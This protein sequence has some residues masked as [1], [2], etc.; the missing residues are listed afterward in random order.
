[1]SQISLEEIKTAKTALKKK[2]V[3]SVGHVVSLLGCST[4][5]VRLK[6]K[7]WNAYTSYNQNGRY[8]TLPGVPRFDENGL[9]RYQDVYFSRYGTL[10][11][12]VVHLIGA[13][14]GGLTGDQLGT[15][16]G[17]SPRSF[18]HHFRDISGIRREKH[19]GVYVYFSDDWDRYKQ[20][21]TNRLEAFSLP[22]E[23]I[24]DA[25]AVSILVTLIQH[26]DITIDELANI[27]EVRAKNL[28]ATAIDGYLK[29]HGLGKKMPNSKR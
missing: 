10:K 21:V 25:D 19:G 20:Q 26:H 5:T 18:L 13:S 24:S 23:H 2:K 1:M 16:V 12:T 28:S 9:W 6:L 8:Y 14:S 27:P 17:I 3:F 4:P 15:I 22:G 29:Q 7:Q 11:N